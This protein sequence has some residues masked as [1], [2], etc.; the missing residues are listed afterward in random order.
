MLKSDNKELSC[1][2]TCPWNTEWQIKYHNTG[3]FCSIYGSDIKTDIKQHNLNWL[4]NPYSSNE[5]ENTR[6]TAKVICK[7]FLSICSGDEVYN[8]AYRIKIA[9]EYGSE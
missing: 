9:L 7:M 6:H 3:I 2:V 5:C 4:N 1:I 8:V